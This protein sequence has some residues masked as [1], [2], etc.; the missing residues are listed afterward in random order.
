MHIKRDSKNKNNQT[1][2]PWEDL[3]ESRTFD[4]ETLVEIALLLLQ[5]VV[6]K[7]RDFSGW[8]NQKAK[9]ITE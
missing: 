5:P 1:L 3:R 8:I 7:L 6:K 4:K 2:F 9:Q